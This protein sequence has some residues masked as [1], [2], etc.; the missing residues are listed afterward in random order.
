MRA[1]GDIGTTTGEAMPQGDRDRVQSLQ[2]GKNS[3]ILCRR[4]RK[5]AFP[6][7]SRSA[8]RTPPSI[9]LLLRWSPNISVPS[10]YTWIPSVAFSASRAEVSLSAGMMTRNGS[11]PRLP[12]TCHGRVARGC[13]DFLYGSRVQLERFCEVV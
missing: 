10:E 13:G 11:L 6:M 3:R 9:C 2:A 12:L 8:T 1:F 5:A 4:V 7:G